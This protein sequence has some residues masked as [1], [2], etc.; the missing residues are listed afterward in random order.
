[1]EMRLLIGIFSKEKQCC[2]VCGKTISFGKIKCLDGVICGDC[3]LKQYKVSKIIDSNKLT[4]DEI[5]NYIFR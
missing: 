1:M 5:R 2:D 4:L 3:Q